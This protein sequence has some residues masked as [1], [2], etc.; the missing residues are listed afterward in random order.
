MTPVRMHLVNGKCIDRCFFAKYIIFIQDILECIFAIYKNHKVYIA[1]IHIEQYK[2]S[3][4]T[5]EKDWIFYYSIFFSILLQRTDACLWGVHPIVE[6]R[7]E[8]DEKRC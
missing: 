5:H 2:Y 8:R 4:D 1:Y 3:I 7:I 6:Y